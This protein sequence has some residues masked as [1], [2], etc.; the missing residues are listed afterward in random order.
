MTA[1]DLKQ[2]PL[3]DGTTV[4]F[5]PVVFLVFRALL[6][7]AIFRHFPSAAEVR[8]SVANVLSGALD[9]AVFA[10][11]TDNGT[12]TKGAFREFLKAH[13]RPEVAGRRSR[14]HRTAIPSRSRSPVAARSAC[15][16]SGAL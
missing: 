9:G 6:G 11:K 5:M 1:S 4:F 3:A 2:V 15:V 14:H 8:D 12:E 16:P 7:F 10:H 13:R